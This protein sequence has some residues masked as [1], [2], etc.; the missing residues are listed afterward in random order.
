MTAREIALAE[1]LLRTLHLN[2]PERAELSGGHVRFSVLVAAA[3]RYLGSGRCLPEGYTP[4]QDY[5]GVGLELQDDGYWI[6]E[7]FE[8]GVIRLSPL[9]SRR[10]GSLQEAVQYYLRSFGDGASLDGAPIAWDE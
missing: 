1:K 4:E 8:V 6:H 3:E 7:R 2:V 5:D 10:A 9:Q